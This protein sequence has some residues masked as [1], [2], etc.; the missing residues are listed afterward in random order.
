MERKDMDGK[1]D[2]GKKQASTCGE[3]EAKENK[4]ELPCLNSY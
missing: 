4:P 3:Q 2:K 1:E